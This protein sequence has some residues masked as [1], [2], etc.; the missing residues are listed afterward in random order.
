MSTSIGPFCPSLSSHDSCDLQAT[1]P[2][3]I[4]VRKLELQAKDAIFVRTSELRELYRSG[5]IHRCDNEV[6]SNI[7]KLTI[8]VDD[9]RC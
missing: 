4:A 6:K 2:M 9:R 1:R 3:N 8:V 5:K 7:T